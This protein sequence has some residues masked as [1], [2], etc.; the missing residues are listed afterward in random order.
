[1][2]VL[3]YFVLQ[4]MIAMLQ[5]LYILY[6][7]AERMYTNRKCSPNVLLR[8]AFMC[9]AA[10][11]II[12]IALFLRPVEAKAST[13][14]VTG[15]NLD[16]KLIRS[17][18]FISLSNGYIRILNVND[19]IFVERY[20][21]DFNLLNRR[22]LPVELDIYGGFFNGKGAYYFVFGKH[23]IAEDTTGEVLRVVK[24]DRSWNRTGAVS[25]TG[26]SQFAG[27]TGRRRAQRGY[28]EKDGRRDAVR[29]RPGLGG[30]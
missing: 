28:P 21:S 2:T 18:S 13:I 27:E 8:A 22:T 12:G 4:Y 7:G 9:F 11:A 6:G 1:M 14:P 29:D 17:S 20:D 5:F 16:K 24:Y 15:S 25:I 23:N 19:K 3:F 10:A 30:Y 26:D